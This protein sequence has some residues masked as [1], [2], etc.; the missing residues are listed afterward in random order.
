MG[1]IMFGLFLLVPLIEIA[2]FILM[3][4]TIGLWPTLLGVVVTA[5]IGSF[6]IRRQGLSLLM[7]VQ[8]LTRAGALPAKQVAEG[9]M[10]AIAGALLLTPGYFT[11]FCGFLLLVPAIRT[12]I[13]DQ[14]KARI[15]VQ[16]FASTT[17]TYTSST[18]SS[19]ESKKP[20]S[21]DVVDLDTKD[22]RDH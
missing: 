11:D 3:G 10:L 22:W 12:L 13:Y 8:R 5:L 16:G 9:V 19:P 2:L 1:L 4:Q 18:T 17:Q 21:P 14:L 15:V 6:V 20:V 7:E